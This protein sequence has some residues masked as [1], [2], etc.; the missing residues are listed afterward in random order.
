MVISIHST[1]HCGMKIRICFILHSSFCI[2]IKARFWYVRLHYF[3]KVTILET[4]QN[5][6][7][8][9]IFSF[10]L[11]SQK[12]QDYFNGEAWEWH[13]QY[14]YRVQSIWAQ[15]YGACKFVSC[16]HHCIC[17]FNFM[18]RLVLSELLQII[19]KQSQI[20]QYIERL[21]H[22]QICWK[23]YWVLA[24]LRYQWHLK[25]RAHWSV[26]LELLLWA[27]YAHIVSIFW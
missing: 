20:S 4:S 18:L 9:L 27:W 1:E 23:V 3:K 19:L 15:R 26:Q 25:M 8:L 12:L 7:Q 5:I 24:F 2:A 22:W 14:R 6:L 11:L 16:F 17:S 21:D 10:F 13:R